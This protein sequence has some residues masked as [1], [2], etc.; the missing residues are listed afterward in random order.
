MVRIIGQQVNNRPAPVESLDCYLICDARHDDTSVHGVWSAVHG[1]QIAIEYTGTFHAVAA[2]PQQ[3][4]GARMENGGINRAVFLDILFGENGLARRN[5]PDHRQ[6]GRGIDKSDAARGTR[7]QLDN[8]LTRQGAQVILRG[9]CGAETQ[10]TGNFGTCRRAALRGNAGTDQFQDFGLSSGE[11]TPDHA[12]AV[13]LSST[14]DHIQ[15][16][17]E[18]NRRA[19]GHMYREIR[20]PIDAQVRDNPPNFRQSRSSFRLNPP[21]SWSSSQASRVRGSGVS[22][23]LAAPPC[24]GSQN[25]LSLTVS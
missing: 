6:A 8:A 22:P 14:G 1:E 17:R 5:V 4:I 9:I 15:Q 11:H 13:C 2:H 20:N 21:R 12:A 19:P 18:C 24:A 10:S 3:V 7:H 23:S 16:T 25:R